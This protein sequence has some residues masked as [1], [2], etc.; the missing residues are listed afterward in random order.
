MKKLLIVSLSLFVLWFI[1]HTIAIVID[2]LNDDINDN[3]VADVGVVLGNKVELNGVPSKRLEAR[4]DRA[5]ELYEHASI[6]SIIVSGGVGKEGFDEAE[7]MSTYLISMGIPEENIIKDSNGYN[8]H[9]T[10]VNSKLI[11]DE[12]ELESVVV[13]TQYHHITRTKLAFKKIGFKEVY[14]AHARI[15]ELRD[16]YAIAREFLAYYKYLLK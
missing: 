1:I 13:I 8:T 11:M 12:L 7:V 15:F 14:S 10:A 16:I 9:L 5:A 6:R 3:V 2:G 4:L